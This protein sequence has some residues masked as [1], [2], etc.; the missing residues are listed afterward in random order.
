MVLEIM[1]I[2]AWEWGQ[3][4]VLLIVPETE[5]TMGSMIQ[6]TNF[7]QMIMN[8]LTRMEMGLVTT[9]MAGPP[10]LTSGQMLTEMAGLINLD[11]Y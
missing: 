6:S 5:T 3:M 10:I 9:A 8:G 11:M 1:L 7:Q 4:V 2:S